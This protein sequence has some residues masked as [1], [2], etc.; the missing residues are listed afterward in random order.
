[1]II[2]KNII[3]RR[4]LAFLVDLF[5]VSI[6]TSFLASIP[7]LNPFHQQYEERYNQVLEIFEQYKNEE[8]SLEE[9]ENQFISLSYDLNR[10]NVSYTIINIVVMIGYFV[11]FAWQRKG[12]TIGKQLFKLQIVSQKEG[13]EVSILSYFLRFIVLNNVII[14][15]FQMI[16]IFTVSKDNYYAIYN[17]LNLVGYVILYLTIFFILIR[18]DQRGLHDLVAG[19]K[20]VSLLKENSDS[21]VA[22]AKIKVKE[23]E[24][25]NNPTSKK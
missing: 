21:K 17:N 7:F 13:Q 12:K 20:V 4:F 25:E 3:F 22:E 2:L 14:T 16:V 5:F 11:I 6:I 23:E 8:L 19:T 10:M 9:Y 15:I 24:K 18:S 1:M